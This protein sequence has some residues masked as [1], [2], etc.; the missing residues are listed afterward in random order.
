MTEDELFF[1]SAE[2]EIVRLFGLFNARGIF[3]YIDISRYRFF[4]SELPASPFSQDRR[5]ALLDLL[6]LYTTQFHRLSQLHRPRSG[7]PINLRY[8]SN[9]RDF[10]DRHFYHFSVTTSDGPDLFGQFYPVRKYSDRAGQDSVYPRKGHAGPD[11]KSVSVAA[12]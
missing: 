4:N 2:S 9:Y 1:A 8:R 3:R 6:R 12:D 10:I 7:S 11:Q 5:L